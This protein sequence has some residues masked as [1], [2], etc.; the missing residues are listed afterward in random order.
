MSVIV[1]ASPRVNECC[2]CLKGGLA[3]ESQWVFTEFHWEG[4][5]IEDE[6]S[7]AITS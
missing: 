7:D 1:F 2:A 6:V 5:A 4:G 3:W